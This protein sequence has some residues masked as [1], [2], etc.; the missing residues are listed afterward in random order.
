M[1]VGLVGLVL[2]SCG[3]SAGDEV[4]LSQEPGDDPPASM[5]EGVRFLTQATFGPTKDELDRLMI[6]GLANWVDEQLGLSPSLHRPLLQGQLSVENWMSQQTR[7]HV[8][9]ERVMRAPDQLRQKMA[10]SLSQTLVVSTRDPDVYFTPLGGAEYYDILLRGAFGS[11]R[12][13]LEEVTLSPVMGHYLDMIGN[14]KPDF[15]QNTRPDENFAREVLQLFSIG[16]VQLNLDGT[17]VLDEFGD[18]IPTYGQEEVE[19]FAQVFT[20][21]T[22][23]G[24]DQFWQK[25]DSGIDFGITPMQFWPEYFDTEDKLIL[26]GQVIGQGVDGETALELALDAI[27]NHPNVGPFLAKQ[28]IQRLVTSNPA[29]AYVARVA[30]V[31]NNDGAGERGNLGAV[32]RAILLD[33]EARRLLEE[34]PASFGKLREPLLRQTAVWRMFEASAQN[35]LF[36]EH[37]LTIAYA[38]GPLEAPSVFNFYQSDFAPSGALLDAG[39]VAPEFQIV[40]H[41]MATEATNRLYDRTVSGHEGITWGGSDKVLL[42]LSEEAELAGDVDALLDRLEQLLMGGPMSAGMRAAIVPYL[43]NIPMNYGSTNDWEPG[44]KRAVEA[45][46]LIVSSPEGAVQR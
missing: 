33:E 39:M 20:G 10:W 25:P 7:K 8:W 40:T 23:A 19:G 41:D 12:D 9:W 1:A 42:E 15:I 28:L 18:P 22:H 29:P 30:G 6:V 45:V 16:L 26:D 38:Q 31:F 35:N 34:Q 4:Q 44:L 21:W 11:Y 32:V 13:L 46:F 37:N 3:G 17:P 2:A 14:Q 27:A 43:E 5:A 24:V 36:E